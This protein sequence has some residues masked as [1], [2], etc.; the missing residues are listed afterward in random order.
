[1]FK[2]VPAESDQFNDALEGE[3]GDED[4]VDVVK[5][6]GHFLGLTV[7]LNSHGSHVEENDHHDTDIKPLV[8]RELEEKHL[9]LVLQ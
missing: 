8:H 2:E 3:D 6:I 9:P 7:A 4:N 1:L 5:D